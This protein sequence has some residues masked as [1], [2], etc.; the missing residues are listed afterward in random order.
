[1]KKKIIL[2]AGIALVVVT[3]GISVVLSD[4]YTPES[5]PEIVFDMSTETGFIKGSLGYPSDEIPALGVCAENVKTGDIHCTYEMIK[6]KKYTYGLGYLLEVP[7]GE[8]SVFSHL[9]TDANREEGYTDEERAYYSQFVT[10]GMKVK[11]KSHKP[12][13]VT[14]LGDVTVEKIDPIDWYN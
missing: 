14:V 7:I 1:M 6:S 4:R 5:S 3:L 2:V 10:C 11:C 12:I 13:K 8:Y 9:V